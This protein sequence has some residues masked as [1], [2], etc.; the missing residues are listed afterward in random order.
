MNQN[1]ITPLPPCTPLVYLIDLSVFHAQSI[2]V[3][4]HRLPPVP[5]VSLAGD[6]QA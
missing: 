4:D 6:P 1:S 3:Q 5:E 2:Q